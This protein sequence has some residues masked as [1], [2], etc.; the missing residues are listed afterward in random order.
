MMVDFAVL[1]MGLEQ[2]NG[3]VTVVYFNTEKKNQLNAC[4]TIA[5]YST[6]LLAKFY[7]CLSKFQHIP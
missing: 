1:C 4:F 3:I 6:I 7:V 2:N 5:K